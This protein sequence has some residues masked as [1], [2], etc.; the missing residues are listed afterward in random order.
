MPDRTE[1]RLRF[2]IAGMPPAAIAFLVLSVAIALIDSHYRVLFGDELGFGLLDICRRFSFAHF[3][4]IQLTR[5]VSFDPIGYNALIYGM[6]HYFGTS[7]LAMRILPITGYL[8]MQVCLFQIVRRIANEWAA[9][10]ALVMPALLGS[11]A[12]YSIMARPYGVLLGLAA[13]AALCWQVAA[14][15]EAKRRLALAGLALSLAAAVNMQYYAVLLFVPIC[16]AEGMRILET[17]RVDF[18][19]LGSIA[20]GLAGLILVLPFAKVLSKFQGNHGPIRI[21]DIH[22]ITHSYMWLVVGYTQL[23]VP[24]MH[25]LGLCFASLLLAVTI[26]FISARR[27]IA[28]RLTLA[29]AVLLLVLAAMPISAFVLAVVVTHFVEA[30]YI[31]PAMIGIC[32]VIAILLTPLSLNRIAGGTVMALLAVALL[33]AGTE[34]VRSDRATAQERRAW[35]EIEPETQRAL[36]MYPGL[37]ISVVSPSIWN[38][39]DYYSPSAD[40]RSR[41]TLMYL[42]PKDAR[43]EGVGAD[44]N[45]QMANMEADGVP[46]VSSYE[47]QAIPGSEHLFLLYQHLSDPTESRLRMEH[48]EV[49]PLGPLLGG[50]LV[51]ARFP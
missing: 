8:L 11:G 19:M 40:I 50:E 13:V 2:S 5:P 7:A 30:R 29:E 6:I 39:A 12:T 27:R 36:D 22:F 41:L 33:V 45:Q 35:L 14:R 48:A 43:R 26:G 9:T 17:K 1:G 25:V 34:R 42:D 37:P 38:F 20:G 21:A 49:K 15:R 10:V 18:P 16:A 46:L 44:V 4:H 32:S 23:S 24:E 51:W 3:V 31:L 28:L 47:E